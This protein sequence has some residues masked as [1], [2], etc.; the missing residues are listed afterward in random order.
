MA[1]LPYFPFYPAD[2]IASPKVM[3]LTLAQQG[4]YI[5]VLC[6]LWQSGDCSIPDDPQKLSILS[7]LP[8]NEVDCLGPF[9]GP[10]PHKEGAKTNER[11]MKEWEKAHWISDMRSQAGKKSGK[12][13]RTLV[14]HKP[15]Q[16][17]NKTRTKSDK[18]EVRSQ[19]HN[20]DSESQSEVTS[21]KKRN[22]SCDVPSAVAEFEAFWAAYPRKVG[23]KKAALKAWQKAKD[24]PPLPDIMAVIERAKQTEQWKKDGGQFIPYPTTWLNKGMWADDLSRMDSAF[25]RGMNSFLER[26]KE[27]V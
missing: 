12:S 16:N 4:A 25:V 22:T 2:W 18:S 26:H 19:S 27:E 17:T 3:C 13:R 15:E 21:Q 6:A 20:S 10:H 9:L 8:V 11:L 23:G 7:G 14:Q 1:D 5:R 24:R